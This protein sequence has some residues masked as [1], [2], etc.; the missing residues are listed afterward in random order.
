MRPATACF[1]ELYSEPLGEPKSS[2][3]V[4]VLRD[5]HEV[6]RDGRGTRSVGIEDADPVPHRYSGLSEHAAE[7]TATQYADGR[8]PNQALLG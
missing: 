1:V 7:L 8:R 6:G 2:V 5:D 4:P 3:G